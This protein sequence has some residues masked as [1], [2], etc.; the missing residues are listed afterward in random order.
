MQA[1]LP[2]MLQAV[3]LLKRSSELHRNSTVQEGHHGNSP[4]LA[5]SLEGQQQRVDEAARAQ[6]TS[7]SVFNIQ[8][9]LKARDA[10]IYCCS[11]IFFNTAR[12]FSI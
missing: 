9:F 10:S 5:L 12:C 6:P 7:G 1:V 3:Q 4:I 11:Y 2:P 8:M